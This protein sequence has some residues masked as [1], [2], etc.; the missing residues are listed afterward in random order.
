MTDISAANMKSG[1]PKIDVMR[2]Q[3]GRVRGLGAAKSGT[4]VWWAERVT[5]AALVPLTIYFVYA[6][7]H[8][9]GHPRIDVAHWMGRPW[10]ATLM[11]ALIAVTF[12]HMQMGLQ[13]VIE[14]YI[15]AEAV[16]VPSLLLNK[17]V[18]GL[19]GLAAAIAVLKLAFTA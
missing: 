17:A 10:N 16:R 4:A 5:S 6:A 1:A 9:S 12:H 13:V 8:L 11:I 18:A 14:D 7:L 2:S 3:L 19:L 15:H